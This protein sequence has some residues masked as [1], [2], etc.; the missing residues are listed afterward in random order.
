[1]RAAAR[2][3][4]R[5]GELAVPASPHRT[6]HLNA[7]LMSTG[8][9]EASWRLPESDPH[10]NV[11]IEHYKRLARI[12]ERGTFDSLFLADGPVMFEDVAQRPAGVIEPLTLLTVLATA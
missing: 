4:R 3:P 9:H 6:L 1:P 8:H 7:F 10:S 12:A 11:D 2:R 5:E